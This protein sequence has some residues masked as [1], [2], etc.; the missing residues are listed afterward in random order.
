MKKVYFLLFV[1]IVLSACSTPFDQIVSASTH[2]QGAQLTDLNH[3]AT[4]DC[5]Y[6]VKHN[7]FDQCYLFTQS[8]EDWQIG[9]VDDPTFIRIDKWADGRI[10]LRNNVIVNKSYGLDWSN[11]DGSPADPANFQ[12][13]VFYT[14]HKTEMS[15]GFY[16]V[17]E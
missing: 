11:P 12:P 9:T 3:S 14:Y 4:E 13:S 1:M 8:Y 6:W 15:A 10:Q 16:L 7:I 5:P 2:F 17:K